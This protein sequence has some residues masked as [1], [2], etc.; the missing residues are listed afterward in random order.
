MLSMNG[1]N[2]SYPVIVSR[3]FTKKDGKYRKSN[4]QTIPSSWEFVISFP[5]NSG[6][7]CRM[8]LLAIEFLPAYFQWKNCD[9]VRHKLEPVCSLIEFFFLIQ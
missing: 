9:L 1:N 8:L 7:L 5:N 2:M 3:N 6:L 4:C